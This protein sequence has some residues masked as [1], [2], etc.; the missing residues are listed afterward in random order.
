LDKIINSN[1]DAIEEI[2]RQIDII[3]EHEISQIDIDSILIS[4][5][6]ELTIIAERIRDTV[7]G[8]YADK[9]IEHGFDLARKIQSKIDQGKV[10]KIEDTNNP[11]LNDTG[12]S[13]KQD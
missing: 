8:Q 10:I 2:E 9:A 11:K 7:I 13:S 3:I 6:G 5:Q 1:I 12:Q 4:P